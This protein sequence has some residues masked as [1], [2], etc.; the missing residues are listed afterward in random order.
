[1]V[2]TASSAPKS[3]TPDY[4]CVTGG[5]ATTSDAGRVAGNGG[6]QIVAQGVPK[7]SEADK[8]RRGLQI[9]SHWPWG[10]KENFLN[11]CRSEIKGS[12]VVLVDL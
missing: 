1:M 2:I 4:I 11:P 9:D 6:F 10:R 3:P 7:Q 8:K 12:Q 5:G